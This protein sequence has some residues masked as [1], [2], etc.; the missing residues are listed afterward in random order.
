MKLSWTV[1]SRRDRLAIYEYIDNESPAS[2]IRIDDALS[3]A[4]A[5]LTDQPQS[6]RPGR[7]SGTREWVVH[8]NYILI[9]DIVDDTIRVLR[10]LHAAQS[11]PK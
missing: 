5:N 3:A 11:W 7:V 2:A 1:E 4:A 10:V 6:G 9:Y 8:P